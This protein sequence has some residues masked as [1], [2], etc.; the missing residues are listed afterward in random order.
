MSAILTNW[1]AG[2]GL[3]DILV[4]DGHIHIGEW[5]HACTFSSFDEAAHEATV[6]LDANGVDAFCGFGGGMFKG[7][8]YRMGNDLLIDVWKRIPDRCIPFLNVNPNDSSTAIRTELERMYKAGVRCI[9]LINSYQENYPGD[10]PNMMLVYEFASAHR[11]LVFNHH[12]EEP[13]IRKISAQFPDLSFIYAHYGNWMD[14]IL[15]DCE[16]VYTNIWSL[17]DMG[18][19]DRGIKKAGAHKFMLGSD[20]FLN[21]LSVGIGPVVFADI[22]DDE[23]RL[24]LGLNVARLLDSV[25]ALPKAIKEKFLF[26]QIGR[27]HV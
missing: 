27:A 4:I 14:Q 1:K 11:L 24:I 18:W 5:P 21:A 25:G 10:G 15:I 23:K 13:V 3:P 26:S 12:W 17:G 6:F 20:G 2:S 22:T 16:N 7:S 9:K 8:D 19:L